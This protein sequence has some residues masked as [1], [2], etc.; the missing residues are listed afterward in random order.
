MRYAVDELTVGG[1][2]GWVRVDGGSIRRVWWYRCS[3]EEVDQADGQELYLLCFLYC[4]GAYDR[5]YRIL[6]NS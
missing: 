5:T 6:E 3:F 1:T 2:P 4:S